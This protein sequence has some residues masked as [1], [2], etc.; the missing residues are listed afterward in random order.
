MSAMKQ[1]RPIL[2]VRGFDDARTH[3]IVARDDD[4][5][6]NGPL[7]IRVYSAG[8]GP[9]QGFGCLQAV[10]DE[11]VVDAQR[12]AGNRGAGGQDGDAIV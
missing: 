3:V 6:E 12:L 9:I 10:Y 2:V 5:Y 11:H 4:F 8:Q 7:V 1:G